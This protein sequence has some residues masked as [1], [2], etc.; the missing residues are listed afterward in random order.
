MTSRET[1]IRHVSDTARWA[2]VYRARESER[3]DALFK[4]P[5]AR[6]LA[7]ERG[8]EIARALPFHEK[9]SWSWVTRT[10]AFDHFV[11]QQ[12]RDGADMVVNLAAGLD[13]RP[14]R[15]ALPPSLTWVE[16][17][18]P[19]I[20]SYKEQILGDAEPACRVERVQLD[21]ADLNARRTLFIDLGRRANKALVLS[22]GLLIYLAAEQVGVLA[23]DL[24]NVA[25]FQHW[26]LDIA[27]PALLE[28]IRRNTASQIA[29]GAAQLQFAPAD[30]PQFFVPYGWVPTE[31]KSALKTARSLKRLPWFLRLISL[32]PENPKKL[33]SRPWS[34]I[35]LLKNSN[36]A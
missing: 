26:I 36:T 35:C 23:R 3:S 11:A 20:L 12:I 14:Y 33:S 19:G 29:E 1:S 28:M 7:G 8:E 21:L 18:L 9:N 16:V 34:G 6:Q 17:D 25:S 30:G 4:D 32:L 15:M 27:S 5:W 31:V 22:E 10:W 24:A 2:A 13:A